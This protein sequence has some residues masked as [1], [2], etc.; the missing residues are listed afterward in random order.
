MVKLCQKLDSWLYVELKGKGTGVAAWNELK[1]QGFKNAV[2][3]SF[4]E[5]YLL[6]LY[7]LECD[8]P[9]SVLV[10]M[11]RDPFVM[12][13]SSNAEIIHLCWKYASPE[14][15]SLVTTELLKKAKESDLEVILWD[16][17]RPKIVQEL[18]QTSVLGICSDK[19]EMLVLYPKETSKK[20]EIVCH[21]GAESFAPENT[22]FC[23]SCL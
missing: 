20:I 4:H 3:A 18:I 8:Y 5:D 16:E 12:A 13:E 17:D 10:P 11:G 15:F 1:K 7:K 23:R 6:E 22:Y 21:R 19:P 14:P 9:L 2:L